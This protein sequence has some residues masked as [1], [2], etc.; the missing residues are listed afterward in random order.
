M[1]IESHS[2][3]YRFLTVKEVVTVLRSIYVFKDQDSSNPYA[4]GFPVIVKH[5]NGDGTYTGTLDTDK[6]SDKDKLFALAAAPVIPNFSIT[7]S[8]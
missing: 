8:H 5:D 2:Y 6:M 1:G 7:G 4:H 3:L